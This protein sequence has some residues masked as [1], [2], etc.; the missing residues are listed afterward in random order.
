MV[1]CAGLISSNLFLIG[2]SSGGLPWREGEGAVQHSSLAANPWVQ[3]ASHPLA[4]TLWLQQGPYALPHAVPA[5]P[6]DPTHIPVTPPVGFKLAQD[7]LTGQLYL[8]PGEYTN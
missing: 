7:S 3:A 1:L 4:T 8:I 6:I 5:T 2:G